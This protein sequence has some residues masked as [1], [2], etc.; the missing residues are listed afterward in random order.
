MRYMCVPRFDFT[1]SW[2]MRILEFGLFIVQRVS[3]RGRA[4][5]RAGLSAPP[6]ARGGARRSG[7]SAND[8][9]SGDNGTHS[10]DQRGRRVCNMLM[11]PA[12]RLALLS[13]SAQR[14]AAGCRPPWRSPYVVAGSTHAD[15]APGPVAAVGSNCA[16]H[17]RS[18]CDGI[19]HGTRC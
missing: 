4:P 8:G 16:Q 14:R 11:R 13:G 9:H 17:A 2:C 6:R 15:G 1:G 3:A 19:H 12:L 7:G 18:T 5:P 10:C